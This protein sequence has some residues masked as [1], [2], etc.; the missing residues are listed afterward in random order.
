MTVIKL[1]LPSCANSIINNDV[2]NC[3]IIMSDNFEPC[4]VLTTPSGT[5]LNV[6]KGVFV[7]EKHLLSS[8]IEL[9]NSNIFISQ[10]GILVCQQNNYKIEVNPISVHSGTFVTFVELQTENIQ[11]TNLTKIHNNNLIIKNLNTKINSTLEQ[12][13]LSENN[14][15]M[16]TGQI[17]IIIMIVIV[18]L[19][20]LVF[21]AV[22]YLLFSKYKGKICT[23]I[24]NTK[25]GK[26]RESIAFLE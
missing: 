3:E 20:I 25:T 15:R 6:L 18:N 5:I 10:T 14:F 1:K 19:I 8:N 23:Q 11:I 9:N 22:G 4:N 26:V 17:N 13:R 24:Y 7:P 16:P 2:K 21:I 12:I